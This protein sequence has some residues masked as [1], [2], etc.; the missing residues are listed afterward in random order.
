M[1]NCSKSIVSVFVIKRI[2]ITCRRKCD[3]HQEWIKKKLK[4]ST[5]NIQIKQ[6]G[7]TLFTLTSSFMPGIFLMW[8]KSITFAKNC[9]NPNIYCEILLFSNNCAKKN[10][11]IAT[12]Y[13]C[14]KSP[15]PSEFKSAQIFTKF[16]KP[17]FVFKK[18]LKYANFL[19]RGLC[20]NLRKI[21]FKN[22]CNLVSFLIGFPKSY[23]MSKSNDCK[24]V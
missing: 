2:F 11:Q 4:V 22:L 20:K 16:L 9:K 8:Y 3:I 23:K 21:S 6:S 14:L 15:W 17:K 24:Y 7:L 1:F 19:S 5:V 13:K 12:N 10:A 18:S